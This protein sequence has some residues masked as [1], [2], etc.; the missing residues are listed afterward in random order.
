MDLFEQTY[1]RKPENT[2]EDYLK[3][4][5]KIDSEY[6]ISKNYF[7]DYLPCQLNP[8]MR[9]ILVD[10]MFEV[11]DDFKLKRD[12]V[13]EAVNILDRLFQTKCNIVQKK[14]LQGLGIT[15]LHIAAKKE[16]CFF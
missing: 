16:V 11:A 9:A 15:T 5:K 10:W 13:Y 14:N 6:K 2:T 1:D 4:M 7:K 8:H 3:L 12:T